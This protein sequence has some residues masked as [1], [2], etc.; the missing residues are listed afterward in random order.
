MHCHL[1]NTGWLRGNHTFLRGDGFGALLRRPK[2]YEFPV[3]SFVLEHPDGLIAIDTGATAAARTPLPARRMVPVP[4]VR[5]EDEIGPRMRAAGL[6]PLDVRT[7]VVTHLDWDHVGGVGHFP[8]AE[9]LIHRPEHA[10]AST[11]KGRLRYQPKLW[12][13]D[14]SP[15]L[16]DLDEGPW[17]GFERSRT[18]AEGVRVVPLPG[19]S[20]GQVGVVV[21]T[22]GAPLMFSADHV[23]RLDWFEEDLAAGRML[24]LGPFYPDAARDT[25]RRLARFL[26]ETGAVLLPSHD[27]EA[28]ARLAATQRREPAPGRADAAARRAAPRS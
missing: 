13:D 9:V 15:T 23:L 17:G 3:L 2:P 25:S 16:Y 5:P 6:D 21:E 8:R 22:D 10:F 20:I 12:P 1:F 19:H 18:V 11:L 4:S 28:P 7:V 14:F 24:G 27:T 26:D